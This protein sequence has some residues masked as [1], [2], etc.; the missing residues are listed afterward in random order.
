M[1]IFAP[2]I[3]IDLGSSNTQVYVKKRGIVIIEPTL[4]V[5]SNDNKHQEIGRAHV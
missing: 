4:V 5:V 2:D 3:G 1:H